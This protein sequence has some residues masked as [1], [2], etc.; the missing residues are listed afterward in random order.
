MTTHV[1]ESTSDT[2]RSGY[3]GWGWNSFPLGAGA[4]PSDFR[5]PYV[6]YFRFDDARTRPAPPRHRAWS[7]PRRSSPPASGPGSAPGCGQDR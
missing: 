4:L 5:E 3:I 2:V 6:H 1:A 7:S